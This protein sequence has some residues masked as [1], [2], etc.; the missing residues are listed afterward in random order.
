M[1]TNLAD[2]ALVAAARQGD[3]A[4]ASELA[5]RYRPVACAVALAVLGDWDDAQDVAQDALLLAHRRLGQLRE[6]ERYAA[7]LR[8]ITGRLAQR[9]WRRRRPTMGWDAVA[10]DQ[11]PAGR[12]HADDVTTVVSLTAALQRLPA[13]IRLTAVL[14]YTAQRSAADIADLLSVS[15][16]TVRGRLVTARRLLSKELLPML[17]QPTT[18][19]R[20][21][22]RVTGLYHRVDQVDLLEETG[23]PATDDLLFGLANLVRLSLGEHFGA[24]LLVRTW[25]SPHLLPLCFVLA[26]ERPYEAFRQLWS[27]VVHAGFLA[28]TQCQLDP[29][30]VGAE[31]PF[32]QAG[33]DPEAPGWPCWP[34]IRA[35]VK[36]HSLLLMGHDFRPRIALPADPDEL[37]RNAVSLAVGNLARRHPDRPPGQP[38]ADPA[39]AAADRGYGEWL[40]VA[41]AV[42]GLA[43]AA[44]AITSGAF[45]FD[46][47]TVA[48]RFAASVGG[49]WSELVRE[50]HE[51]LH[52]PL[53]A[54]ERRRRWLSACRQLAAVDQ[55]FVG[56]VGSSRYA[57]LSPGA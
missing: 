35:A 23:D 51:L 18:L 25:A 44:V 37:V 48:D 20:R 49:P 56:L 31:A 52:R 7:W 41:L 28:G 14:H 47:A 53:G 46:P 11:W 17:S 15:P 4:A 40:P 54:R 55:W 43:R 42:D 22:E 38:L 8:Q 9:R 1:T 33:S 3:A 5:E 21:P 2:G 57:D 39:P 29:L 26:G 36:D 13:A 24:C 27:V 12:D 30:Y 19:S 50:N 45:P 10:P 34:L 16:N 6:G 32:L